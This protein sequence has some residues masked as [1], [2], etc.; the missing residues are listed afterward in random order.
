MDNY[1]KYNRMNDTAKCKLSILSYISINFRIKVIKTERNCGTKFEIIWVTHFLGGNSMKHLIF[2]LCLT[3]SLFAQS[4]NGNASNNDSKK[5]SNPGLNILVVNSIT[6]QKNVT[7][8]NS[9]LNADGID[10]ILTGEQIIALNRNEYWIKNASLITS[11]GEAYEF[12]TKLKKNN[13]T[14]TQQVTSEYGYILVFTDKSDVVE[15]FI[16]GEK[17]YIDSDPYFISAK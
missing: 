11:S 6:P 4:A 10:E 17:G 8:I 15:I 1:I 12:N 2:M 9:D 14:L 7:F 3:A 13:K 16:A 5:E